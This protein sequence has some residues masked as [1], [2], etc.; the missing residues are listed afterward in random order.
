MASLPSEGAEVSVQP[1]SD[2]ELRAWLGSILTHQQLIL[3]EVRVISDKVRDAEAAL[4]KIRSGG[5][6]FAKL[7]GG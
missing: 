5:G 1:L 2:D 3:A 7:L 4:A 6:V